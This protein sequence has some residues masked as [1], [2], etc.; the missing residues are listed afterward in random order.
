MIII[1]SRKK[2]MRGDIHSPHRFLVTL[3]E[4]KIVV[5]SGGSL[6]TESNLIAPPAA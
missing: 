5:S 4:T 1:K 2:K 6:T 3:K